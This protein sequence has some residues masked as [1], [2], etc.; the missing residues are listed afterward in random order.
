M[1]VLVFASRLVGLTGQP[2]LQRGHSS[3]CPLTPCRSPRI[4]TDHASHN[5]PISGL[6]FLPLRPSLLSPPL[7]LLVCHVSKDL[8]AEP[9]C[10]VGKVTRETATGPFCLFIVEQ[11]DHAGVPQR[12]CHLKRLDWAVESQPGTRGGSMIASEARTRTSD[13]ELRVVVRGERNG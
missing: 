2:P 5:A 8:Q 1:S 7:L 4:P 6:P 9:G 12:E 10:P 13:E 3:C 11:P